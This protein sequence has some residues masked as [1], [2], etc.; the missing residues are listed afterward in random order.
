MLKTLTDQL[1]KGP[2]LLG[3]KMTAADVLWGTAL[4]WT[5]KFGI[6]PLLPVIKTYIER[7]G[8]RP[9]VARVS[10]KDAG[11]AAAH[12]AAQA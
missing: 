9:A 8:A 6:V 5:T 2:Y 12:A 11:L 1:A 3:E 4:T 7:M 10:A